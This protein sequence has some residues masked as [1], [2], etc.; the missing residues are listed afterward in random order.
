MP[1]SGAGPKSQSQFS[2]TRR[3]TFFRSIPPQYRG[4]LGMGKTQKEA[5]YSVPPKSS[6]D[7]AVEAESRRSSSGTSIASEKLKRLGSVFPPLE[8]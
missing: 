6:G 5:R 1:E 8:L 2:N 4:N 7:S 3:N